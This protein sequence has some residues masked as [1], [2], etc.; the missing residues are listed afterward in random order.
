MD[1]TFMSA[2]RMALL[3]LTDEEA[4]QYL[5]RDSSPFNDLAMDVDVESAWTE[6]QDTPGTGANA[7]NPF[8]AQAP[9]RLP[10]QLDDSLSRTIRQHRTRTA[11][12]RDRVYNHR[13]GDFYPP[14]QP[15]YYDHDDLGASSTRIPSQLR[16]DSP[17]TL[18]EKARAVLVATM[19]DAD[20]REER[21]DRREDRRDD[22]RDRG[23][24]RGNNKRRRDDDD[25]HYRGDDRR[26]PQRRRNDD[27]GPRR[28]YEEPPFPKLRRLLLNIASS[29]KLPQDEAIEIAKYFGEH[30]DDERL[31][32]D[33][34]DVLVQLIIEQPFK[35]PFV[36]AVAYYA[37]DVKPQITIEAMKRVGDRAQEALNAGEWKEFKLL[38]RF[39]ACLQS[40][41]EDDGVFTF[42]G[43]LFDTVVDLQSANENDVVGIELVKIILLTI[44]YAIVAGGER[45]HE[46][47]QQLLKNTGIVASN[48]VPIESLIHSYVGDFESKPVDHHSV[49]GLLQTQLSAEAESGFE[50]RCLPRIDLEALRRADAKEEDALPTAPQTHAFPTFTIPSPVNPG[51]RPVFPEAYFSLFADQEVDT[52]PK[53]TD[54]ASSLVRDAIVDTINQLDFNREMVAKFLVDVDCYW[55]V[56]IFAKRGSPFDKFR[57]LVGDKIQYKSEDMIIDA[58]FSQLFKLPSAEHKLVYY[59]ALITQCCKV[60]PAAIAPSLGR[61]IRTIYK[62]LPMMDLELGYRFLDW[63]SHH[64]SNFEFRWRWTEWLEDLELSNLHPKKAFILAT[65]DKEIRLS[66]AKRIRST[67]PE[68]MHTMIPERLDAD[69]SPDFK[70]DNQQ[71]PYAAE[72][73]MLLSQLRKK[74]T[75]EEIQVTIDSIHEKA[76]EQG[77]AEV[78]VPSTDAFVTAICRL[79]AKSLSHVLSCIERG[80]D[81]LLELSQNEVARRQIVAS[82]VEYWKDQPGV[83]VRIIDILLNYTILAPMTV[84]QWVFGSHMGAGEALTESWVFEMVSNTVAKVTNRNRQIASARLQKGLPQEQIEMVEA[85]LAKDRDN[86]RELFKYIEDS[87]RGVAEG[88]ADTLIEKSSN[89]SLTEEEVELIK[90]WGKRWQT[91]FIRKAQVEES[92]VG[93]EAVE[94]RIRL[95]AAEPDE[96]AESM[97]QDADGVVE[98]T[99][100]EAQMSLA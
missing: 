17:E 60:A 34:F 55:S 10:R 87:M 44:P 65:L 36:A 31:R 32:S 97:E 98:A 46:Q 53:T 73:Q 23:N 39:F 94:A 26:G 96:V 7:A 14:R 59:H 85:T 63:F 77:I 29:T 6:R 72:G 90:A 24:Y 54:I 86:A 27:A 100:G 4:Q 38:L 89:G 75:A 93:E 80:K 47:A 81:R 61:A 84:V 40:L 58:I 41:Y 5:V 88:S 22:R 28:R 11:P 78:L 37:N 56:D 9:V 68:P 12:F 42:L 95:L 21:D 16:E 79:G 49:I 30:F 69:N 92:V 19:A 70:Y 52:V 13:H 43:Q 62:N 25:N 45:F 83:A 74:A 15:V 20:V 33:F 57:E 91:V 1:C 3:K 71:T 64:L 99:N 76:L 50:L 8:D 35:I 51:P 2:D 18:E 66:F 48:A 67:L 82:V